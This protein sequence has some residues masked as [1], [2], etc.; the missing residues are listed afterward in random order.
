VVLTRGDEGLVIDLVRDVRTRKCQ[1]SGK[2]WR[3]SGETSYVVST[4]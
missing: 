3:S 1:Q 2:S 4:S